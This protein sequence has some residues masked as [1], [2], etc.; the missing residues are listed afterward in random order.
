MVKSTFQLC[1]AR[2]EAYCEMILWPSTLCS[3]RSRNRDRWEIK[4]DDF[5]GRPKLLYLKRGM[6]YR[7][8][9]PSFD[10]MIMFSKTNS[11]DGSTI[12]ILSETLP[13]KRCYKSASRFWNQCFRIQWIYS[14]KPLQVQLERYSKAHPL[15]LRKYCMHFIILPCSQRHDD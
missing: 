15:L 11:L 6:T 7:R 9:P 10:P 3:Q 13:M 5:F 14:I 4:P 2:R 12:I 1:F 8:V